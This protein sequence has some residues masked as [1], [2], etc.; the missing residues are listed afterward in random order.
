MSIGVS[1]TIRGL[2]NVPVWIATQQI[3]I[4]WRR[5]FGASHIVVFCL[6]VVDRKSLLEVSPVFTD[7]AHPESR[8]PGQLVLE[9]CVPG[10][11][12]SVT[13][14]SRI[15]EHHALRASRDRDD[16]LGVDRHLTDEVTR[17]GPGD[18]R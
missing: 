10:L 9:G 13:P 5:Q 14:I 16:A 4:R 3:T 1:A 18:E 15:P 8:F 7:I 12:A 17:R 6:A 11:S 2:G